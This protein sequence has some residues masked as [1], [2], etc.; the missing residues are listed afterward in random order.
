MTNVAG[1]PDDGLNITA[2][3]GFSPVL[4]GGGGGN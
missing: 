2:A 3:P 4:N 1:D